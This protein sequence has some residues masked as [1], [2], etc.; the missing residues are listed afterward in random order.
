MR[1]VT[2]DIPMTVEKFSPA[3]AK[4]PLG[5]S[6]KEPGNPTARELLRRVK[7]LV[8]ARLADPSRCHHREFGVSSLCIDCRVN[9]PSE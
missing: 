5:Q 8:T 9:E 4:P 6:S 7:A 1:G 2:T 3:I